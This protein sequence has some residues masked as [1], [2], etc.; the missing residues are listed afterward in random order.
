MKLTEK[1]IG[2]IVMGLITLFMVLAIVW[3]KQ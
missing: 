1:Q 2:F 3:S